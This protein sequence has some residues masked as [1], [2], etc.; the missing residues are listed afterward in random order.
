MHPFKHLQVVNHHR[1]EVFKLCVRCGI[2]WRGLTHDLS[3]YSKTEFVEGATYF[4]GNRSPI[5]KC[6]ET[7][8]YSLAWVHHIH[9]NKHHPEFWVDYPYYIMMPYP[10]AVES[11]CDRI[12]ACKIYHKKKYKEKDVLDYWNKT[13]EHTPVHPN[14]AKFYQTV[15]E[16]LAKYGEPYILNKKY[17]KET[18][19]KCTKESK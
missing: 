17:M 15:F 3:K 19:Q 1:F 18:Y 5:Q 2:I 9:R 14:M 11:I 7:N 6:R 16:D 10:Y 13:K 8:G 12:A 4:C